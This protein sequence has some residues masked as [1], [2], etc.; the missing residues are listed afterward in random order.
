MVR[1]LLEVLEGRRQWAIVRGEAVHHLKSLPAG[2][3]DSFVTD[4][5]YGIELS[6]NTTG[7]PRSIAGDGRAEARLLWRAWV[8]EAARAAR[9]DTSHAVFGTWKSSW[10]AELLGASFAVKGCIAWDKKVIGLGH[11]LRPRWE[12]IYFCT[13]G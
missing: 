2:S 3:I 5:P 8:P 10:M 13:K 4:P 1:D 9:P 12:M 7:K 11:Y 6:L